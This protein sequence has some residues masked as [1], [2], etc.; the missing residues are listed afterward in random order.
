MLKDDFPKIWVPSWENRDVRQLL[1][2]RHRMV[3]TRTRIMN[4]SQ[5]AALNEGLRYKKTLWR[6]HGPKTGDPFVLDVAQ[7]MELRATG[8][9]RFARGTARKSPW[10]AVN[11]RRND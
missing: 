7:R 4:Q 1:W 11:H 8:K 6:C 5:A 10:C 3:Q 9:L 2:H